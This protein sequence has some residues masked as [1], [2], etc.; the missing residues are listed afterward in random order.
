MSSRGSLGDIGTKGM[1]FINEEKD[2]SEMGMIINKGY[3]QTF[4]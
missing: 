2:P 4:L 3:K 1:G